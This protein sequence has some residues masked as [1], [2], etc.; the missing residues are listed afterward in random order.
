MRSVL[1]FLRSTNLGRALALTPL[2]G[3]LGLP[4]AAPALSQPATS[5]PVQLTP[6]TPPAAEVGDAELQRFAQAASEI[7]ELRRKWMP[8]VAAAQQSGGPEAA[9]KVEDEAYAE[10]VGAVE[11]KGLSLQRFNQIVALAQTDPELQQR[12]ATQ[13]GPSR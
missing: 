3:V 2:V 8:E 1:P 5:N 7:R 10:M 11:N 4:L 9:L 12:L 13:M 6:S